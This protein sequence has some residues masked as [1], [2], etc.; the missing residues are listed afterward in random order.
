MTFRSLL[1][2]ACAMVLS[3]TLAPREASAQLEASLNAQQFNP[4]A[5]FHEFVAVDSARTLP[6]LKPGFG[7]TVNYGHRVLQKV[8]G[9]GN[10]LY[11]I[12]DGVVGGDLQVGFGITDWLEVD[13]NIPFMEIAI[14]DQLVGFGPGAH[15]SLG[16]IALSA[17]IAILNPTKKPIGIAIQPIITFPT[18]RPL[19]YMSD[20]VP[21]F[22]ARASFSGRYTAFHWAAHAGYM[23]KPGRAIVDASLSAGDEIPFGAAVGFSPASMLDINLEFKGSAMVGSGRT[24]LDGNRP[25]GQLHVPMELLPNLRVRT[26]MGLDVVVG[27]GPG[28]TFGSGSPQFRVFG[29]ISWAPLPVADGDKDGVADAQDRCPNDPEDKDDYNDKDGCPDYDNDGDSILDENDKCPLD[30]EDLDK[31]EDDDGCPDLDNDGDG[32]AD[33]DDA[34]PN[35]AEDVD[36]FADEDGCPEDDADEDGVKDEDDECPTEPEDGDGFEDLNGCPDT[37]NDQDG[38][39][40]VDDACPDQPENVNGVKDEDGCPDDVQ[41]VIKGEK[42]LI[43]DKVFFVTGKDQIIQKSYSVLNAV[44]K[45]LKDNPKIKKVRVEGHTDSRAG[46]DINQPLS[47]RRAAA[48][49]KYLV[50]KGIDASRLESVGFGE[51]RPI[52]TNDTDEGMQRNRR[53]EF[54]ILEQEDV[55]APAGAVKGEPGG[56]AEAPKEEAPAEEAAPA[57][58]GKKKKKGKKGKK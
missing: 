45:T 15:Y 32:I 10:R 8:D 41:A 56:G 3:L 18:G 31:F 55:G 43:L 50:K 33:V 12:I 46:Q 20:G 30:R 35:E 4:V 13:L 58:N 40:D 42:I 17:K 1:T 36:G 52:D 5:G 23:V 6:R 9:E 34:C 44:T 24:E 38:I 22:G 2:I 47:E 27:G 19:L 57:D 29:G 21:T 48:V 37:D 7:L 54:T 11:G 26:K 39:L 28:L 16:D 25:I 53:V 51:T 49:V 14:V